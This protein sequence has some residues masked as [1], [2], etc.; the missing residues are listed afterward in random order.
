[1]QPA[2]SELL[3]PR[4]EDARYRERRIYE[5]FSLDGAFGN[6]I[7]KKE[8]LPC[9]FIDISL[10]GCCLR[11]EVAFTDG[12]LAPVEVVLMLFG[13]ILRIDGVTQWTAQG[14]LIGVR[15]VHPSSRSKNQLAGL[16][17]CLV[18]KSAAE[19]VKAAIASADD[20][21]GRGILMTPPAPPP[22]ADG[23]EAGGSTENAEPATP[24]KPAKQPE[25]RA[26]DEATLKVESQWPAVVRF[27][28]G[29]SHLQGLIVDLKPDG[30][31][32]KSEDP[33][34]CSLQAR[35]ELSFQMRGLPFQLAGVTSAFLD[36]NTVDVRFLEMSGR[37][38][39]ELSQVLE[40]LLA[41]QKR[42][43]R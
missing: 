16:L 34:L 23:E 30:C 27:L 35:V 36:E 21:P 17:T 3:L 11:L 42:A 33:V 24:V 28:E 26:G 41:E 40:E 13:L 20:E 6:L 19:T 5:R 7:Y 18:D 14:N 12:A 38:R 15:F 32:L 9:Q 43:A 22:A 29:R 1:M 10:S 37:K 39:E 2:T 4:T 25:D 8:L 31:R